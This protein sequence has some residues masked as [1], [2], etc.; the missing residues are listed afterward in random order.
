MMLEKVLAI[1]FSIFLTVESSKK[2]DLEKKKQKPFIL[3]V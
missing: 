3:Q 2:T 1:P